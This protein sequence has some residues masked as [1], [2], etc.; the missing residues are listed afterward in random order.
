MTETVAASVLREECFTGV[1]LEFRPRH[2]AG[3]GRDDAP[4]AKPRTPSGRP[5]TLIRA[6][7]LNI[8]FVNTVNESVGIKGAVPVKHPEEY[9]A[10]W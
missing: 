4:V 7:T 10:T 2:R 9:A 1:S 6:N 5:S 3:D 8:D